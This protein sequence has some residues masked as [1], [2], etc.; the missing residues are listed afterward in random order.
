MK[1]GLQGTGEKMER[2]PLRVGLLGYGAV[3]QDVVRLIAERGEGS[4]AVVGA[5]VRHAL[6][7]RPPGPRIVTTLAALLA[8]HPQVIVEVAGHEGLR[9]HGSHVLRAG[10]DLLLIS[11]GALA[12]PQVMRSLLEAAEAGK[13]HITIAS[14]AIG[15]LDA[16]SAASLGGLTRVIHTIRRPPETVL[17]A[18]EAAQVRSAR[19][20]FRGN[21]RQGAQRFPKFLNVA[22]AIA[23]AGLG[24]DQTEVRVIADPTVANSVHEVI[25]EGAFG[26]LR[27]EIKNAPIGDLGRGARLV[28]MSIVQTLL[29]RQASFTI[30]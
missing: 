27:F 17:A 8:D 24:F 29:A 25:A 30:G 12:D 10:V 14:G 1:S 21:V 26:T 13:A 9:E 5:L 7:S 23:L 4:I 3:G 19:E 15:G 6:S 2:E 18:E 22:A 28:A 16:L 20:I 11:V